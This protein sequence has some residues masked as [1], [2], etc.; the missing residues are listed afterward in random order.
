M[1]VRN[2]D[3]TAALAAVLH[4][5]ALLPVPSLGPRLLLGDEGARELAAASQRVI[6]RRLEGASHRFRWPQVRPALGHVLGHE[7][8]R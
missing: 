2:A 4:R 7:T 1:P 6:P 8:T 5:P 3:Y